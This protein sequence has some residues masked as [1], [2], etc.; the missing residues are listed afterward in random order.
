M[1][2]RKWETW[3]NKIS[4]I[5][6]MHFISFKNTKWKFGKS[7]K[8]SYFHVRESPS[9][10]RLPPLHPTTFLADTMNSVERRSSELG[11]NEWFIFPR[12]TSFGNAEDRA[13]S[14][15][16]SLGRADFTQHQNLNIST[17]ISVVASTIISPQNLHVWPRHP[18]N[19]FCLWLQYL[20]IIFFKAAN[21]SNIGVNYPASFLEI[22]FA[23]IDPKRSLRTY[24]FFQK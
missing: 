10:F 18:Q 12:G 17:Q 8:L 2:I 19:I 4:K 9:T 20:V 15:R 7:Y 24:V 6:E 23:R 11:G 14:S 22:S 3:I 13:D 1:R 5:L 16:Y 21:P